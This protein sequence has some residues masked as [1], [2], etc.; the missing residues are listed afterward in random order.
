MENAVVENRPSA[1][2]RDIGIITKEIKTLYSQAQAIVTSY[3]I[4]IGRR[5]IEAKD[6]VG[7]GEWGR[8]LKDEVG[9]SQSTANNYMRLFEEYGDAQITI[10]GAVANSQTIGNLPYAKALALLAIPSE[11]RE[12]FA[13]TVGAEDLS[14]RELQKAIKERDEERARAK[15]LEERIE[16]LNGARGEAM[17]AADE[18]AELREKVKELEAKV[19]KEKG[20][21]QTLKNKLSAAKND[22]KI[23][24]EKLD[25]I[26]K[27]AEESAKK[28]IAENISRELEETKN[29]LKAAEEAKA[30][31]EEKQKM[32]EDKLKATESRL[33]TADP[34]VNAF[35][36]MFEAL[37]E[38]ANKCN[39]QIFKIAETN[40]E[41]AERLKAAMKALGESLVK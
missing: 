21:A 39:R 33:K 5:L 31:A 8:W 19:E 17:A 4:E 26:K 36:V 2:A 37:Q 32:A 13:E 7:H 10:F 1:L 11:E 41:A 9:F 3:A 12:E 25:A 15:E 6:A 30:S 22:P 27:E 23:P 16:E 28:D 38:Q 24:P 34:E 40:P 18:A 20:N 35:K 29:A 14:V